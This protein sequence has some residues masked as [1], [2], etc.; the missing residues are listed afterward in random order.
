MIRDAHISDLD[1]IMPL[2][3][4]AR[5]YM[6]A[7]GNPSQWDESY[8]SREVI[9]ADIEAGHCRV[10]VDGDGGIVGVFAFIF[11]G[12][13][14]PICRLTV[15]PG[16]TMSLTAWCIALPRRASAAEWRASV[17]AGAMSA[18]VTCGSIPMPTTVRFS[19]FWRRKASCD[20]AL[21]MCAT[22]LR[23]SLTI[24][25]F[26]DHDGTMPPLM[27]EVASRKAERSRRIVCSKCEP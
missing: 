13:T 18:A 5:A 7:S 20:A 2:F 27:P 17:S 25:L 21:S 12:L 11:W 14:L 4:R 10:L 22:I 9:T 23:A 3:D 6:R 15:E 26:Y 8:P 16:S 19:T 1:A 24:K